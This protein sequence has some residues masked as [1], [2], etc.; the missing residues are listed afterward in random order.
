[1]ARDR[2]GRPL[3]RN[4]RSVVLGGANDVDPPLR[5]LAQDRPRRRSRRPRPSGRPFPRTGQRATWP[6]RNAFAE[7]LRRK[8]ASAGV[9]GAPRV[10]G[11]Q[12][13]RFGG[14]AAPVAAGLGLSAGAS[15]RPYSR[16]AL[17]AP[18]VSVKWTTWPT[19]RFAEVVI[20]LQARKKMTPCPSP[21]PRGRG[22]PSSSRWRRA[23]LNSADPAPRPWLRQGTASCRYLVAGLRQP[24]VRSSIRAWQ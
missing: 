7:H 4:V 22:R 18:H 9:S 21:R 11:V 14:G 5:G 23:R 2:R 3:S 13:N 24:R 16:A 12:G 1:M 15:G 10:G 8:R 6:T 20:W 17:P 19:E